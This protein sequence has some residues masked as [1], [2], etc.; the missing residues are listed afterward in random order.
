MIPV[1]NC[2]L[3][4]I[5]CLLFL[6]SGYAVSSAQPDAI[7]NQSPAESQYEQI[8]NVRTLVSNLD[9]YQGKTVTVYAIV[10]KRYPILHQFTISDGIGCPSCP[11][12]T[13]LHSITVR[14]E[15]K[16]PAKLETVQITGQVSH[17]TRIGNYI[18]AS[19]VDA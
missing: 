16:V 7:A 13:A 6:L 14:Y 2:H 17:D 11:A 9:H 3:L 1:R 19:V 15:G 8:P 18:N 4:I 12:K 10:S 5:L